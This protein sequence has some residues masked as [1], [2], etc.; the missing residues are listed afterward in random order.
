MHNIQAILVQIRREGQQPLIAFSEPEIFDACDL[1]FGPEVKISLDFLKYLEPSGLRSAYRKKAFETHPD[2]AKALGED[3]VKMNERF[4]NTTLAYE[5]LIP[6]IRNKEAILLHG[7]P[8]A[9]NQPVAKTNNK[10]A[11]AKRQTRRGVPDLF[12]THEIPERELS[13]SQFLY[14]SGLISW[15][16]LVAATTWQ[17]R[18]RPLIGQIALDWKMISRNDIHR[19]LVWRGGFREKFGERA[20]RLGY[21]SRFQLMALLGKQRN[22]QN[23]IEDFFVNN[24]I[25]SHRNMEIIAERQNLHNRAV[26]WKGK[27]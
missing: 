1:L 27:H 5:K 8:V 10:K 18:Q 24:K 21:L 7:Q 4:R 6:I 13:L 9:R 16:T 23:P 25:L 17:R 19:I 12:Y 15:R 20:I 2:R 22:L 26:C 3:A 11:N 14:Y